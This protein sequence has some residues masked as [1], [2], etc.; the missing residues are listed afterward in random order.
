MSFHKFLKN[1]LFT[2]S[3]LVFSHQAY[4]LS[5]ADKQAM[6]KFGPNYLTV[7]L[8]K[9]TTI[10]PISSEPLTSICKEYGCQFVGG[11]W[12]SSSN[13]RD[14]G[15]CRLP[16]NKLLDKDKEDFIDY[17]YSGNPANKYPGLP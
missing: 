3:L 8:P 1:L 17:I 10:N 4:G 7:K 12:G 9:N 16:C 5:Q 14:Y 11:Y 2:V 6:Q 15:S 13:N